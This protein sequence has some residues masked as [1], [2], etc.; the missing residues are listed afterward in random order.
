MPEA[1]TEWAVDTP[2]GQVRLGDLTL[3]AL[4]A[5]EEQASEEWWRI[6]AHPYRSAKIAKLVYAAACEHNGC[7]PAKLTV[8]TLT[9]VFVQVPEDLPDMFEGGVPKAE[10]GAPTSGSPGSP[11]G[12]D[13]PPTR[14]DD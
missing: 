12:S 4:V 7:E 14:S 8:R 13:G 3:D 6:I 5:L 10:D 2:G 9:D 11:S 1:V